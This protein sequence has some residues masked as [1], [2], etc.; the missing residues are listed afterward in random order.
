MIIIILAFA[1]HV[2]MILY[3]LF[4]IVYQ[5]N[6]FGALIQI[7]SDVEK[8]FSDDT[9]DTPASMPQA[10][11][12]SPTTQPLFQSPVYGLPKPRRGQESTGPSAAER[13]LHALCRQQPPVP[14]SGARLVFGKRSSMGVSSS[15]DENESR[16]GGLVAPSTSSLGEACRDREASVSG[17]RG[18]GGLDVAA[19]LSDCDQ[20][21]SEA[22]FGS[23]EQGKGSC[24]NYF[25]FLCEGTC[26]YCVWILRDTVGVKLKFPFG[27][28]SNTVLTKNSYKTNKHL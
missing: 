5:F 18:G 27:F 2:Y 14:S 23:T 25:N 3:R 24:P 21:S 16:S 15:R 11:R 28:H 12:L 20:Q 4:F 8:R 9:A 1:V 7:L 19:V 6:F 22:Q 26:T 13:G 17:H 10:T